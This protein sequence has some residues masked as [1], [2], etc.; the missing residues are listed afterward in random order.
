MK[1]SEIRSLFL[2][3]FEEWNHEI[4]PSAS[5][6]PH[7][8]PTLLFVNAGMNPFKDIFLGKKSPKTKRATSS[9]TCVRVGGKHND[10]ENVGFTK[11]HLTFFEMLGNFSF[12]DYFKKEAIDFAWQMSTNVLKLDS[13]KIHATVFET[14]DESYA[15]WEKYLP[16]ERIHRLG[17]ADNFWSMGPIGPCGPCSELLYDRGPTYGDAATP[18]QDEAG[19]RFFEFWNLVFMESERLKNGKLQPLPKKC[20]DTGMGLERLLLLTQGVDSVFETDILRSIITH[21]EEMTNKSYVPGDAL[22]PSFQVIADHI[23]MLVF[24]ISDGARPSNIERGYVV[25]KVLRRAVRHVRKLGHEGLFLCDLVDAVCDT[26]KDAYPHLTQHISSVK[27]IIQTEEENFH[28]LL[29]KGGNMLSRIMEKSSY[30]KQISGEDAF[31]LKDTYGFPIEEILLMAKDHHMDV[32]M[33]S[34]LMLEQQAKEK[35]QQARGEKTS[36][37][38]EI[39]YEPFLEKH[40]VTDY[41]EETASVETTIIGLIHSGQFVERLEPGQEGM[42]ILDRTPFY[43]EQGGQVGDQGTLSQNENHFVVTD[44]RYGADKLI[45]HHGHVQEGTLL[46]GEP[47]TASINVHRRQKISRNHTATHLLHWAINELVDGEVRQAGSRVNDEGLRFDFTS[48][49]PIETEVLLKIEEKIIE[50]IENA[51]PVACKTVDYATVQNNPN[52]KQFFEDK[53]GDEVRL[54]SVGDFSQ[55]LCG[56]SHIENTK[57]IGIFRITKE[58]SIGSNIRRIEAVTGKLAYL[59]GQSQE[60]ILHEMC[61]RLKSVPAKVVSKVDSLVTEV[62]SLKATT[63][64]LIREKM[65]QLTTVLVEEKRS[66]DKLYCI[67]KEVDLSPKELGNLGKSLINQGVDAALLATSYEGKCHLSLQLSSNATQKGA[68]AKEWMQQLSLLIDGKGGGRL[69]GAQAA[70]SSSAGISS[71]IDLFYEQMGKL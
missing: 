21:V 33:E 20:V 65:S 68:S 19:E 45:V 66:V 13:E 38:S 27:S 2:K 67:A 59:Y 55:E 1:A 18:L 71:A 42:V 37:Y 62:K 24:A 23:R 36:G 34:F 30:Q 53:Y 52:V 46:L 15:L 70:G 32:H 22:A 50:T 12:G 4:I 58:K 69:D 17:E 35:S 16:Q 41:L 44:T 25:R 29:Q 56:G 14:D 43:A 61:E 64:S 26:M 10:L 6:I 51:Y 47:M 54:V 63:D 11:R 40:G 57:E 49:K 5:V 39:A 28:R 48:A 9:Q 8:D 7:Q 31:L 3:K 60:E